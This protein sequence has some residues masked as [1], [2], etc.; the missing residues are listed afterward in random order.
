MAT[1]NK[2]LTLCIALEGVMAIRTTGHQQTIVTTAMHQYL[3]F[4]IPSSALTGCDILGKELN[5]FLPPLKI[6]YSYSE[7]MQV[8]TETISHCIEMHN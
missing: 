5:F 7:H 3:N 8:M 6:S 2:Y 1:L 4:N